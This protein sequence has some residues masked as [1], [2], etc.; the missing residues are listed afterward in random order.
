MTCLSLAVLAHDVVNY[1]GV[2]FIM[3]DEADQ[4]LT[5]LKRGEGRKLAR[6]ERQAR[7]LRENLRRR[8]QQ[9]R[10]RGQRI[11]EPPDLN[12]SEDDENS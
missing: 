2:I 12:G 9:N 1:E 5:N 8:K 10:A 7:A 4:D 6:E 3:K 11:E